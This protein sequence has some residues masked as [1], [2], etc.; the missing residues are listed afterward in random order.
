MKLRLITLSEDR[1]S[2]PDFIGQTGLSVLVE[3]DEANI[4]F[5]TGQGISASYNADTLGIELKIVD[6]IVLSHGHVDHTGGLHEV[7]HKIRRK[8]VEIVAHPDI[9]KSKYV[10]IRER[11]TDRFVGLPFQ[12]AE[13]ER[14][15]A[16]FRLSRESTKVSE[17]ICTTGEIPM[18]TQFEKLSPDMLVKEGTE[19]I[20]DEVLDEQALIINTK[21]GLI[22]ILGCSHRGA[23]NAIY[24]AQKISGVEKVYMVL[25]GCHLSGPDSKPRIKATTDA[26]KELDVHKAGLCHCTGLVASVHLARELGEGFFFNNAGSVITVD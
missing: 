17:N 20:P 9:W 16:K 15:G 1:A 7:L 26:L 3:S 23:I 22:I 19:L 13:L 4:L 12:H 2:G 18:R 5:D 25:G 11:S 8:D 10:H 6:K 24:H 14:L 21:Y